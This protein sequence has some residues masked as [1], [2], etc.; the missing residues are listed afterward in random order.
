[1]SDDAAYQLTKTFWESKAGMA[2]DAPWWKGVDTELM[3]NISTKLHPGAIRY[4]TEAGVELTAD[5]Q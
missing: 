1:M 2:E 5:Q 4:Y 3:A